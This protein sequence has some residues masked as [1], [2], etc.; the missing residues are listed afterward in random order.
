M[1][2]KIISVGWSCEGFIEQTLCSIKRQTRD[3][4]E[5]MIVYDACSDRGDRV[6]EEWC[7]SPDFCD[8]FGYQINPDQRFAVRNQ[9]DG[10]I[11]LE[12]EDEDVI[13]FLDLDGDQLAHSEVLQQL[14]DCYADP[15]VLLTYGNYRPVPWVDTCPPAV[16]FPDEVVRDSSY[17]QYILSG[18]GSCFNHLRTMKGKVFK[19]IPEHQFKW[20]NSNRWLEN[21]TD[22]AFMTAGLELAAGRYRCLEEVLCLYNHANPL[23]DN[24]THPAATHTGVQDLLH[25]PPLAPLP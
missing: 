19:A 1:T 8:H 7:N 18:A 16:P 24:I 12:V 23:A 20:Q 22:Y 25:R 2:F 6:I 10:L 17:R 5:S 4:W 13:V 9:Y 14:A 3:D 11:A 15:D 21:G